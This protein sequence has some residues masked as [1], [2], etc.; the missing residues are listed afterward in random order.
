[1]NKGIP[2]ADDL[3]QTVGIYHTE[4]DVVSL[5]YSVTADTGPPV[6]VDTLHPLAGVRGPQ[7]VCAPPAKFQQWKWRKSAGACVF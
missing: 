3:G 2:R 1:M 4:R 6:R 5:I 7:S